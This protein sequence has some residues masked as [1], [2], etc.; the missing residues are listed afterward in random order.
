VIWLVGNKG[1]LGTEVEARLRDLRLKYVATDLDLDITSRQPV[2]AFAARL[3][4]E[5]IVVCAAYTAV[6]QA[7][8]EEDLARRINVD[9]P[10]NIGFAARSIGARVIHVSTDYVF[11]GTSDRPYEVDDSTCPIGAYGRT[12]A[13]GE[14]KLAAVCDN[15]FIVR[16]AWLYGAN[17]KNFVETML[18]LMAERDEIRVVGDQWGTPTYAVDLANALVEFVRQDCSEYGTYHYTN[19]GRTTWHGFAL[20]IQ[21]QAVDRGLLKERCTVKSIPWTEYPTRATRP[22]YSVLSKKRIKSALGVSIPDWKDGLYRY[23]EK[24]GIHG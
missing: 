2:K 12:K 22:T 3:R 5:W 4:P 9:G 20:E 1:M 16:T 15:H 17:G 7:E 8:D 24:R 19:S 11:D 10:E 6:D 18:R 14:V 13:A 21:R 23:L